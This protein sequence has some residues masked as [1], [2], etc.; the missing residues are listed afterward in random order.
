MYAR[1]ILQS[2][3][4]ILDNVTSRINKLKSTNDIVNAYRFV[5]INF[6]LAR[7]NALEER[8]KKERK[9]CSISFPVQSLRGAVIV[10]IIGHA[11]RG[12]VY[13]QR[14][15]VTLPSEIRVKYQG[16]TREMYFAAEVISRGIVW[17]FCVLPSPVV[18]GLDTRR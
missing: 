16:N 15:Q 12:R 14:W 9:K 3:F 10:D 8:R 4:R 11:A 6:Y 1:S 17:H 7:H 2:S 18:H 5:R 13:M